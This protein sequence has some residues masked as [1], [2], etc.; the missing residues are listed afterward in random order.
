MHG[1]SLPGLRNTPKNTPALFALGAFDAR[2]INSFGKYACGFSLECFPP[3]V[4][5]AIHL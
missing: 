1:L 4:R 5:A 2:N 3:R